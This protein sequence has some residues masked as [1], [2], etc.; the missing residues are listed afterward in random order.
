MA[1]FLRTVY[2]LTNE[3]KIA[4]V[5]MYPIQEDSNGQYIEIE[6]IPYRNHSAFYTVFNPD[7]E[8]TDIELE[9]GEPQTYRLYGDVVAVRG[10]LITLHPLLHVIGFGNVY[11]IAL[12][13]GEYRASD[14]GE[15]TEVT[16]NGGF[17]NA[18]WNINDNESEFPYNIYI[19]RV[20]FSGD[21]E[22]GFRGSGVRRYDIVVTIDSITWNRI[23]DE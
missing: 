10:P 21:E 19:K 11:K 7:E 2:A 3:V 23:G 1:L 9:L 4:Q 17:D 15:G 18:W 8:N 6:Y 5:V 14:N 12:I 22:P 13:E 20:T 16:I